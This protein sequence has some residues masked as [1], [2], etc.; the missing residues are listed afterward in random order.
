MIKNGI[1]LIGA[2]KENASLFIK[3]TLEKCTHFTNPTHSCL[4]LAN[5]KYYQN[6]IWSNTSVGS[7]K[8]F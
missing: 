5:L 8:H 3:S 4:F 2:S 1:S 6:E 7:D